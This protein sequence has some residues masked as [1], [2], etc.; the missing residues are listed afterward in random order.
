MGSSIARIPWLGNVLRTSRCSGYLSGSSNNIDI[1]AAYAMH[2]SRP[3]VYAWRLAY[4][5]VL[6]LRACAIILQTG[7]RQCR[8][9]K[10]VL[11]AIIL[12]V[13]SDIEF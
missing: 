7:Q 3:L 11:N 10:K 13:I 8:L 4:C 5:N 6:A 2:A 12:S 9:Q 1:V